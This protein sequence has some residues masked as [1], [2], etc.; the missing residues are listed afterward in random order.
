MNITL[1]IIQTIMALF[2]LWAGGLK[3][4]KGKS[5][6]DDPQTAKN[7][8]WM[9]DFSNKSLHL[10]G[11]IEVLGAIGL[12]LPLLINVAPLLTSYA[13]IGLA[14]TMVGAIATHIKRKEPMAIVAN[15]VILLI[16]V[17]IAYGRWV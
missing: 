3:A 15:F 6:L 1:W 13:A 5:A 11:T 10:I 7:M 8:P 17:F 12:V 2:F 9:N 14:V 16:N 4:V